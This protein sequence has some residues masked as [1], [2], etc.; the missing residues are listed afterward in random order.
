[1]PVESDR[2]T[3]LLPQELVLDTS[4][5][6]CCVN[7]FKASG[8][9]PPCSLSIS[10]CAS[11]APAVSTRLKG[12]S[13]CPRISAQ[14]AGREFPLLFQ[15][16]PPPMFVRISSLFTCSRIFAISSSACLFQKS[17]RASLSSCSYQSYCAE[18]P[19]NIYRAH[20]FLIPDQ[21]IRKIDPLLNGA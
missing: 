16:A 9:L 11:L 21:T 7:A 14:S 15:K 1:M 18:N 20:P 4:L 13:V 12:K 6:A 3:V 5:C 8:K 19:G 10:I 2:E 17:P